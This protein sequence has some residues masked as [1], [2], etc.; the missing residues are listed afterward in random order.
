MK[1]EFVVLF[2]EN[3]E[4]IIF[5]RH[6]VHEA[7]ELVILSGYLGP[8]PVQRLGTLPL[9]T[10]VIYGMYGADGISAKLHESLTRTHNQNRNVNVVYSKKG[11]HSK[12]YAWKNRGNI[13]HALIGSANFSN[14]GM[15]TPRREVLAEC[16]RDTFRPLQAYIDSILNESLGC[17]DPNVSCGPNRTIIEAI[18][19]QRTNNSASANISLITKKGDVPTGSGLNWGHGK[20]K[21][22][23]DDAYLAIRITFLKQ[24]PFIIPPKDVLVYRG[25]KQPIELIWDDG[26]IMDGSLEG[27]GSVIN[28]EMYPKQLT[29][30]IK[31]DMGLYLRRRMDLPSGTLRR[32][33]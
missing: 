22:K 25:F 27:N 11:V 7:D 32:N 18:F 20:A 17:L 10:S 15:N 16:T 9:R 6:Q 2:T 5:N 3:L 31:A 30:K 33:I 1:V 28:G 23:I 4:E 19:D 24:N 14:K 26:T 29:S 21:N 8:K 12:C 13:T